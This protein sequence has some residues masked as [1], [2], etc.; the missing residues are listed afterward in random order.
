MRKIQSL[1]FIKACGY[2]V[3]I[4]SQMYGQSIQFFFQFIKLSMKYCLSMR[5]GFRKT[6]G[7]QYE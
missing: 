4:T 6:L 5:D 3:Q 1:S 2:T 7:K